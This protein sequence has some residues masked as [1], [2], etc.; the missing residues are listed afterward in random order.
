VKTIIW[1]VD[2]TLNDLMRA[3]SRGKIRYPLI[4]ENPPHRLL[5]LTK[6]GYLSSLDRF[7]LSGAYARLK[8]LPEALRWFRK[9]GHRYR[10][11]ALS[12]VPRKAAHVSAEWVL[13]NFGTW[14]DTFAFVPSHRAGERRLVGPGSK[15]QFVKQLGLRGIF[16]DDN[17]VAIAQM[18]TLGC[19]CILVPR[20]W[21][22]GVGSLQEAFEKIG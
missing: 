6:T 2:D 22:R 3:W 11:V 1:D 13:R 7:R 10:H 5:G 9:H 21:N 16:V 8:P 14:I 12:A 19:K 17:P 15:Q 18:R 20:P 4:S